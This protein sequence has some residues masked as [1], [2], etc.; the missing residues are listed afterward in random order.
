[1]AWFYDG[2]TTLIPI[3]LSACAVYIASVVLLRATGKRTLAQFNV[4]DLI[5][6]IALGSLIATT[7][8][9]GAI[10]VIEGLAGL[11]TLVVMQRLTALAA[12]RIRWLRDLVKSDPRALVIDGCFRHE[13]MAQ[14]G[15]TEAEVRSAVRLAGF[16]EIATVGAVVLE[17]DGR[18][19]VLKEGR[20]SALEAVEG[21]PVAEDSE[22]E[23]S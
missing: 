22:K 3:A 10:S 9:T 16:A 21:V 20:G 15:V 4:L 11:A 23:P 1:M 2:H 8:L 5:F 17:P 14:E 7:V 19:S 13:V 12:Q 6:T 18:L